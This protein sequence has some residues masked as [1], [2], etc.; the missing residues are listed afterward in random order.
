MED[1]IE[2]NGVWYVRE[3]QTEEVTITLDATSFEGRAY[4]SDKYAFE[5]TRILKDDGTPY[6]D[7]DIKFTDKTVKPWKEDYFDNP[8]WFLAVLKDIPAYLQEAREIMCEQGIKEFKS[9]IKDL[10]KI[11]WLDSE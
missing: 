7:C 6:S 9:I 1:R 3:N 10:I 2:I 8:K 4:E 5:V 11:G